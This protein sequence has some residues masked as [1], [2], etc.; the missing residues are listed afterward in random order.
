MI[1]L[2]GGTVGNF[3]PEQRAKLLH[4]VVST[5][6]PGDG[7]LLG[8]DLVK[9][10]DRLVLAYDDPHGVTAAF[11]KNVLTVLNRR[12]G[13]DFDLDSFDHVATFDTENEWMD[14]GLRS[15]TDQSITIEELD[16]TVDFSEGEIL[17]T[18]I[19]AKFR[20]EKVRKELA[21]VGLDMVSWWTDPRGDYA[22]SL[23]L[24]R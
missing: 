5:M 22:V 12:L 20:E 23:A 17:R 8:T 4:D 18:E 2:L 3:E 21:T 14:L 13:A 19:S 11:N 16:L 10:H 1:A 7:F 9:D 15:L 24:L 6:V